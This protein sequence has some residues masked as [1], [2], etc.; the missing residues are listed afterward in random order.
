MLSIL[1]CNCSNEAQIDLSTSYFKIQINNNGFITSMK[2]TT[3]KPA[4]EFSP[5]DKHS[6]LMCLFD[7]ENNVI[8][9][10]TSASF[11]NT[12]SIIT[13]S[14]E[15]QSVANILT[16][17]KE[18]YFKFTLLSLSSR[19]KI[20][21]IQWGSYQTNITNL[22]GEVIGVARD[23]SEATSYAIGVLALNDETTGGWVNT[24]GDAAPF[25]YI[26]HSPDPD[27]FPLPPDLHEGQLFSIGGDGISDVA[28]YS[29]YEDYFRILYGNS[30]SIDSAGRVFIT[31]HS[32]DRRKERDILF[33]LIPFLETNKPNHIEV[34]PLPGV[35]YIGSSIALWGSPDSTALLDVI[36]NIVLSEG[37]PHPTINGKWIKDPARYIP[38]VSTSGGLYDST[39]SYTSQ[40]GFK[41]IHANDLPMY[42]PDR[43]NKGYID[44]EEFETKP[45]NFSSGKKSHKEFAEILNTEGIMIGRHTMA[46]SLAQGTKDASPI[47][48]DSLCY[49][50][51]RL[52]MRDISATDSLIEVND[53]KYLDEI[54]SWE[55][56][57]RNLNMIK[58]GKEIIHYLGVSDTPP[59]LLQNVKRAYWGTNA[60]S[61]VANDTI[62]KLQ[63]TINYGYDGLIPN[64]YLQDKIA[65]YYADVS[66]INGIHF[67]DL[68][69]QEFLFNQGQ[70]Y[71]SVKRFFR[72]MFDKAEKHGIPY[73]RVTGATLSEGSWHYQSIWN[74]GGGKNMYDVKARKWGT[75]TSEGKD[76]RDVAYS[77]YFPATFG[78]NFG[79]NSKSTVAD[80]EHV[81]AISVGVGATYMLQIN[82]KDVEA[83]PQK[84]EIFKA[85][86]TW[87]D[88]RAANAFPRKIKNL[89]ANPLKNWTLESGNSDNN[90]ILHEIIDS[91]MVNS[92][93]LNRSDGY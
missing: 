30:A 14:Y 31:Y 75:T 90:W 20:D 35:D 23:T 87:E 57:C 32:M 24:P 5:A 82:Q 34:Q 56:H 2:N 52:L 50:Q 1:L 10:P 85:I 25:Q 61:H 26:I 47:P 51:K 39:F 69:G 86:R 76:L 92:Y 22:F 58:I 78:I 71:Y 8:Y 48:N 3:I 66:H 28:F 41:A 74:V 59:Y 36:E 83:C 42:K 44:G 13:L 53:P 43:G 81:Q 16:E 33:S 89:L 9:E 67:M 84:Y 91:K 21:E 70:G 49:Q 27:K 60:T 88:A 62:Y 12:D 68:D 93:N 37:L 17:V 46:T 79:L 6:P 29:H 38:D 19:E 80:Y 54:A 64:I 40:L 11:N 18:K 45:F 72:S 4:Q 63:V 77:N 65:E 7:A 15:N 55:G 73:M